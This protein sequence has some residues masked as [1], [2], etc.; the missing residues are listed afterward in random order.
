MDSVDVCRL[1][2]YAALVAIALDFA[3]P[4]AVIAVLVWRRGKK[5]TAKKKGLEA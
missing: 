4:L 1:A 5:K 2:F 3:V